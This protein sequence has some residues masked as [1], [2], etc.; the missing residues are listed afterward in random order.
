MP[1]NTLTPHFPEHPLYIRNIQNSNERWNLKEKQIP[2]RKL[3]FAGNK[4]GQISKNI[5]QSNF[6]TIRKFLK[7]TENIQKCRA[8]LMI[9]CDPTL[10][11][12]LEKNRY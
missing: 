5:F 9:Y 11:S 7:N 6:E 4:K 3:E 10:R 2:K 8:N 12:F 1:T